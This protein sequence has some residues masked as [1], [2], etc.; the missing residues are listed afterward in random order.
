M[1]KQCGF[2]VSAGSTVNLQGTCRQVAARVREA[3]NLG[4]GFC[5]TLM[6]APL[7]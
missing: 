5:Q 2:W 4:T 3:K 6:S 7:L 1:E